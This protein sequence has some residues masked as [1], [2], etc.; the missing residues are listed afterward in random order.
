MD[1]DKIYLHGFTRDGRSI[2]QTGPYFPDQA[3]AIE[4]DGNG[5]KRMGARRI[6]RV[7]AADPT[8][9]AILA[10]ESLHESADVAQGPWSVQD[11]VRRAVAK[12]SLRAPW[13]RPRER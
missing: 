7:A 6:V 13:N 4:Q 5:L 11:H 9:A 10:E 2:G 12:V 3:S 8:A 1:G